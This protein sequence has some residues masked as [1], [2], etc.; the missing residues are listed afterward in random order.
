M[1]WLDRDASEVFSDITSPNSTVLCKEHLV[2]FSLDMRIVGREI[3]F[4]I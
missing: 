2:G 3:V 1:D 4:E